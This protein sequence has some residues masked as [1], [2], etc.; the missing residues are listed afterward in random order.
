MAQVQ[1]LLGLT[2]W[3]M[4]CINMSITYEEKDLEGAQIELQRALESF[5]MI[6][7]GKQ[8]AAR[9]KYENWYRG[10]QKMNLEETLEKTK[11]VKNLLKV[12]EEKA[13]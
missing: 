2:E 1:I 13:L 9:G 12:M 8:L 5:E 11:I 6:T 7:K 10:E 4:H 3:C